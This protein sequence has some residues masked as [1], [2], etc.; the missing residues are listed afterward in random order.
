MKFYRL[1]EVLRVIFIFI[2]LLTNGILFADGFIDN[3]P[4]SQSHLNMIQTLFLENGLQKASIKLDRYGRVELSGE[5]KDKK[6]VELAFS[7][8]QS[9]A[10]VR[11]VSPITPENVKVK[12]WSRRIS[13][14]FPTKRQEKESL[15]PDTQY[16]SGTTSKR[17]ALLV[18]ISKFKNDKINLKYADKDAQEFYSYLI[19]LPSGNF[20]K[21]NVYLLLNDKATNKNIHT[22][23]N[24]IQSLA[25][26]NDEILIYISSH[27][28]PIYDGSMNIITY[29]T[30]TSS[31]PKAGL[32]S[33]W[34]ED[35]KDFI[36]TSKAKNI[37]VVLDVCYSGSAFKNI[38]GFYNKKANVDADNDN[39]G[40]SG[41]SWLR[42]CSEQR[43][44][45]LKT[46]Y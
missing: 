40:V 22:A 32:T 12:E 21:E 20:Q 29:D 45:S 44:S 43:M 39:Q 13:T 27:G 2:I 37:I 19:N 30:D 28:K 33:F 1:K 25:G 8:A 16:P 31:L 18:G 11:R 17:Y 42:V 7:L 26:Y 14:F 24:S 6:E 35:L 36:L 9:V 46:M 5:Y 23:M 4:V 15:G 41:L 3:S 34:S 38:T 10:G